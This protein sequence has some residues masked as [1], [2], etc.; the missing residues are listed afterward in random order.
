MFLFF[1]FGLNTFTGQ[2]WGSG[3]IHPSLFKPTNLNATHWIHLAK[4][5]G[6]TASS[7]PPS[8]MTVSVCGLPNTLTTLSVSLSGRPALGMSSLTSLPLPNLSALT[9]ASTSLLGSKV[10]FML[11][12][13]S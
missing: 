3:R 8:T 2:E 6:L 10:D 11:K 5:N 4:L 12:Q 1:H 7:S 9:S 13:L